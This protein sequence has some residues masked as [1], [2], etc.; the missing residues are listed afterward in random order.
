M[1]NRHA[2]RHRTNVQF[3]LGELR[4]GLG[5][6]GELDEEAINIAKKL[7]DLIVR[8]VIRDRDGLRDFPCAKMMERCGNLI[9][10]FLFNRDHLGTSFRI[11]R[12]TT[13]PPPGAPA[14]DFLDIEVL[15][16][17]G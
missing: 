9:N 3:S 7:A 5:E 1:S 15:P 17:V 2:A 4:H 11:N 14:V 6:Y 12:E 10:K 13:D 16:R 8:E